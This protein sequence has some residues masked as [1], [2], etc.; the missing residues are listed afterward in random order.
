[1]FTSYW[2]CLFTTRVSSLVVSS[3]LFLLLTTKEKLLYLMWSELCW[4]SVI[5]DFS[6]VT[7]L[8]T[9]PDARRNAEKKVHINQGQMIPVV[10]RTGEAKS[11]AGRTEMYKICQVCA[12]HKKKK[13]KKQG[14]I[15]KTLVALLLYK[16]LSTNEWQQIQFLL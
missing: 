10:R 1:M 3:R 7:I 6:D 2:R 16:V 5:I 15:H 12:P 9:S 13:K 8:I 14:N 4:C 11:L